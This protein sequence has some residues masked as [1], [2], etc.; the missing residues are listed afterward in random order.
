LYFLLV[1]RIL[2]LESRARLQASVLSFLFLSIFST[3]T[4]STLLFA[5]A[6]P[7][8]PPK[9]TFIDRLFIS[10]N[11]A[12]KEKDLIAEMK[13][14]ENTVYFSFFRPW[15]G[16]Y[17]FG[18]IFPDSSS[19]RNFFQNTLGEAPIEYNPL[20]FQDDLARLSELYAA[21]GYLSATFQSVLE[22]NMDS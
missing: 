3:H 1:V 5:Q 21:N 9:V 22:Y 10:G 4:H 12:L 15:V 2:F 14:R 20:T 19:L 16:L 13:T 6:I 11:K 18:K 7:T 8:S 17:Q